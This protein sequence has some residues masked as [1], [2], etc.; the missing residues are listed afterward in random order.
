MPGFMIALLAIQY[1]GLHWG[2]LPFQGR[3][4]PL[5][6]WSGI[7][8]M[9]L[10]ATTLGSI[11]IGPI[12]RMTRTAMLEV[13]TLD[14]IRTARAKGLSELKVVLKHALRTA[15]PPVVTLI[16]L[17]AGYLLGG[18]VVTETIFAWPG[19]G[20]LAISAIASSDF[21]MAQGTILVLAVS[22]L[23][24]NLMV[25]LIYCWLDPRIRL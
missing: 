11:L 17:Q 10:P 25:D 15:L 23:I 12:A 9:V 13:L 16:G 3:G 24:I 21:P 7:L 20:R 2:L 14:Y 18:A 19:V 4:G 22:F 1:F 8:H 5:W 6:T